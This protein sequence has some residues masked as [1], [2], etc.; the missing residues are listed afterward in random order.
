MDELKKQIDLRPLSDETIKERNI[1]LEE[2]WMI[3]DESNQIYGPF[4]TESLKVYAANH[5]HLFT[6][7]KV[8]NLN[9]EKWYDTYSVSFFQRRQPSLVSAQNLI[10]NN[11]FF[12]LLNGQ[13]NGPYDKNE[14]QA[15]LNN[16]QIT[17]NTQISLDMGESWIKLYEHHAFDRRTKRTNQELPFRPSQDILEKMAMTKED[18]LKAQEKENAIV[19]LAY[20]GH[21]IPE[22]KAQQT[23]I[24]NKVVLKEIRQ[25][26]DQDRKKRFMVPVVASLV[27]SLFGFAAFHFYGSM[28]SHSQERITA[29][30]TDTKGIDNSSRNSRK[31]ASIKRAKPQ[32]NIAKPRRIKK[33]SVPK[34]YQPK[35]TQMVRRNNNHPQRR[36]D[37]AAEKIDINDPEVQEE[38]PRQL[39]GEFD[40]EGDEILDLNEEDGEE[41]FDEPGTND[42]YQGSERREEHTI[43]DF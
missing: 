1:S 11:H 42:G 30:K 12:I 35:P 28:N 37:Q 29:K 41:F 5:E 19:E 25:Q 16:G 3:K 43:E 24:I 36:L 23:E 9:E 32:R 33:R 13:K 20:L 6:H 7:T 39:S 14:V 27:I 34:R 22:D 10:K 40:L 8:Y 38:I 17:P 21:Q 26:D 18:I 2:L 31:P 4:D 15:F